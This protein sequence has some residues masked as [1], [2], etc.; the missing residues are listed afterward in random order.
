MTTLHRTR[1]RARTFRTLASAMVLLGAFAA[2]DARG[3][4]TSPSIGYS[5]TPGSR[6]A[7]E[8]TIDESL[9]GIWQHKLVFTDNRGDSWLSETTWSFRADATATRT[10]IVVNFTTGLGDRLVSTAHWSAN[11]GAIDIEWQPPR[12]GRTRFYY[13]VFGRS[14]WIGGSAY[15]RID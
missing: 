13:Q 2:C 11:N 6:P 5:G 8:P 7:G 3:S 10:V 14:A 1:G 12:V 15:V 9:L 4:L